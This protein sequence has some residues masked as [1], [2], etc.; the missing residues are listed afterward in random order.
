MVVLF[1][2]FLEDFAGKNSEEVG[3]KM[4]LEVDNAAEILV[5]SLPPHLPVLILPLRWSISSTMFPLNLLGHKPESE[6]CNSQ[7]SQ[8][9]KTVYKLNLS[10]EVTNILKH[11]A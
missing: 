10:Y 6:C 3:H 5:C 2:E 8:V 11:L 7:M 9:L 4:S 1:W